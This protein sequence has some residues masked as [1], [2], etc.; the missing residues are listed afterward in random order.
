MSYTIHKNI[1]TPNIIQHL[2]SLIKDLDFRIGRDN[3]ETAEKIF[4]RNFQFQGMLRVTTDINNVTNQPLYNRLNDI[5][6]IITEIVCKKSNINLKK[7]HRFMWNFYKA[8][9]KGELHQDI[10]DECFYSI[11]YS[12]NTCDGYLEI[13]NEKI[14]DIEDEAKIFKSNIYHRGVGP[15][16]DSFRLNLNI[17]FEAKNEPK[18]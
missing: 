10:N 5:A 2:K 14:Y 16:K 13:N 8:G 15:T 17:V 12:L 7:I 18:S 3:D 6:F 4:T 1:L 11:V 9:E